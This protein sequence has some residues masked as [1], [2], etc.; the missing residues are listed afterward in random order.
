MT[1]DELRDQL[2]G[3][4]LVNAKAAQAFREGSETQKYWRAQLDERMDRI[5]AA[6]TDIRS[7]ER[8]TRT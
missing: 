8:R 6:C 4:L 3:L 2:I 7:T 5:L 1:R